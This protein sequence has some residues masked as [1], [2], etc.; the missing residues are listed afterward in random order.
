[1]TCTRRREV[2][3]VTVTL[4]EVT[5]EEQTTLERLLGTVGQAMT[6]RSSCWRPT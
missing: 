6:G 3:T 4:E 2:M 5:L 1:V